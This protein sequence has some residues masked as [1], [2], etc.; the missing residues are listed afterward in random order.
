MSADSKSRIVIALTES[1]PVPELWRVAMRIMEEAPADVVTIYFEDDKWRRVASLP[2]TREVSR[3]GRVSGFSVT[4]AEEI[5]REAIERAQE[6][7][8]RLAAE[9]EIPS[10]FEVLPESDIALVRKFVGTRNVLVAASHISERP[11]YFELNKLD[12]RILLVEA[13]E[14]DSSSDPN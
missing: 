5:R 12:C 9:A 7:V 2:F 11:I 3:T 6:I 1:S 10:A 8:A 13:R 14:D 4:R